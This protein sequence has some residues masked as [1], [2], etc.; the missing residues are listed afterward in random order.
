MFSLLKLSIYNCSGKDQM[1]AKESLVKDN[2]S[3][4]G[5]GYILEVKNGDL[6][7]SPSSSSLAHC[8]SVDCRLGK[9]IAKIFREKFGRINEI[10]ECKAKVGEIAVLRDR[11]RFIYNLVTKEKYYGKPSY[12]SLRQALEKMKEH[13]VMNKVTE[14]CMPKIGCGLDGLQ[15]SV[16]R[17]LIKN[18][19][20]LEP[21]HLTVFVLGETE[22]D[23]NT[24]FSRSNNKEEQ[25][26]MTGSPKNAEESNELKKKDRKRHQS[27]RDSKQG[28]VKDYFPK[29]KEKP[30]QKEDPKF[31]SISTR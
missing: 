15:W 3:Q 13:A 12:E 14:I 16:V 4:S 23:V 28:S 20:Q 11:S 21:I 17:T 9:G 27:P 25:E 26:E 1:K 19:F 29:I 31:S 30:I 24:K 2:N 8:I 5:S 22:E 18:V 10:K 7:S 6:F